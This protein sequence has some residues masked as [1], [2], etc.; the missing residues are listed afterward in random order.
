M[1][2]VLWCVLVRVCVHA[3]AHNRL[4]PQVKHLKAR[5]EKMFGWADEL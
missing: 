2:D 5:R 3:R 4:V 1:F